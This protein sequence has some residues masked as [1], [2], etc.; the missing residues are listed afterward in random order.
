VLNNSTCVCNEAYIEK[1]LS[2]IACS[3]IIDGCDI[4][5]TFTSCTSCSSNY[6]LN[7]QT[8]ACDKA[9]TETNILVVIL[10][11]A[12]IVSGIA[13]GAYFLYK[14]IKKRRSRKVV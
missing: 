12:A 2:C 11:G 5:D 13:V 8:H 3:S 9:I 14:I 10:V 7:T 1:N 4:C 6:V